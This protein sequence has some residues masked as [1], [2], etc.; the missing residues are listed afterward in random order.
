[1]AEIVVALDTSTA[2]DALRLLDR[3]PGVNWVKVGPVVFLDGGPALVR[4]LKARGHKVFLD[5]KWHDIPRTV[6]GAVEAA[7][8]LGVDLA[9]VHALGGEAMLR[10]A[11]EAA[12]GRL[13]LAAVSVLTSHDEES[14]GAAVGAGEVRDL[15]VEVERL[16]GIAARAGLDAVVCSASEVDLVRRV[17][18]SGS[19]FVV[20]GIRLGGSG[21]DDHARSAEPR[22]AVEAGA[23]HLVIG[24]PII[25]APDPLSVYQR[26]CRELL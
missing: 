15:R 7:A 13:R 23:T 10:A 9:T 5:M 3:L 16:A 20:P 22:R 12:R 21:R 8:R 18:G 2:A 19:W 24:R 14:Y 4:E 25:E 26:V 6:A 1:M 17:M 11:R